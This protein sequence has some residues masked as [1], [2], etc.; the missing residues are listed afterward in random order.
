[1]DT[2]P[3]QYVNERATSF[4]L[5]I[6]TLSNLGTWLCM[7]L[8]QYQLFRIQHSAPLSRLRPPTTLETY[9]GVSVLWIL[10]FVANGTLLALN[11]ITVLVLLGTEVRDQYRV[12]R[13]DISVGGHWTQSL[14]PTVSESGRGGVVSIFNRI[15]ATGLISCSNSLVMNV[16]VPFVSELRKDYDAV[17]KRISYRAIELL[18]FLQEINSSQIR[19]ENAMKDLTPTRAREEGKAFKTV[20]KEDCMNQ[21]IELRRHQCEF[22]ARGQRTLSWDLVVDREIIGEMMET[23]GPPGGFGE[24][25]FCV[26]G[27][28][29]SFGAMGVGTRFNLS[30]VLADEKVV[31]QESKR[32]RGNRMRRSSR[33]T[34]TG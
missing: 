30:F 24:L 32:G 1:M 7:G 5:L 10:H 6:S 12:L 8:I 20:Q 25:G 22:P 4:A 2:Q 11:D 3:D 27:D 29:V 19:S 23:L 31:K 26:A 18:Y 33:M 16:V 15:L 34:V 9:I 14:V 21:N 17:W 13:G 28:S